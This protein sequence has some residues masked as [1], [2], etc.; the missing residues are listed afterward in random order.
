MARLRALVV[1]IVL[2]VTVGLAL[3]VGSAEA[4]C[5]SVFFA[6]LDK[7]ADLSTWW[8]RSACGA[9]AYVE[10]VECLYRVPF[11]A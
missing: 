9:K 6:A 7:C 8:E 3:G 10:F 11:H 5:S 1:A 2:S 4:S